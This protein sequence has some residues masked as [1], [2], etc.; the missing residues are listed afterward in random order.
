LFQGKKIK[1]V[2]SK[3]NC[4]NA[5]KVLSF[6]APSGEQELTK[7]IKLT[8]HRLILSFVAFCSLYVPKINIL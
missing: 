1:R 5:E 8:V 4:Y 7:T 6:V 3:Q 2:K